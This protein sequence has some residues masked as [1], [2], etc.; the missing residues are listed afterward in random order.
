M[1]ERPKRFATQPD[2]WLTSFSSRRRAAKELTQ[3]MM[4]WSDLVTGG[5]L[6]G[7]LTRGES[8]RRSDIDIALFVD[9]SLLAKTRNIEESVLIREL[10][11]ADRKKAVSGA[12]VEH[13][14]QYIPLFENKAKEILSKHLPLREKLTKSDILVFPMSELIVSDGIRA[15][16]RESDTVVQTPERAL[17]RLASLFIGLALTQGVFRYRTQVLST[18]RDMGEAGEKIW[19][20]IIREVAVLERDVERKI[21][22]EQTVDAYLHNEGVQYPLTLDEAVRVYGRSSQ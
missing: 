11:D 3:E 18:L 2:S 9:T 8:S 4:N 14:A 21:K 6:F 19:Q 12:R 7:S 5:M 22:P 1:S 20:K 10:T 15:L 17:Y 16:H 13:F